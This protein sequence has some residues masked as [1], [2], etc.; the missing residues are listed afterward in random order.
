MADLDPFD[1]DEFLTFADAE[2]R[3]C[4]KAMKQ[5]YRAGQEYGLADDELAA[6]ECEFQHHTMRHGLILREFAV[7]KGCS[8]R[9]A[10]AVLRKFSAA[11]WQAYGQWPTG[12]Q[13]PP[14]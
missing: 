6:M 13:H 8:E 5:N 9:Q 2:G 1:F 11:I 10:S 7:S 3:K 12:A 14:N 4:A